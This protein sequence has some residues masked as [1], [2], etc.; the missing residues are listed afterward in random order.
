M[1]LVS[2][3]KIYFVDLVESGFLESQDTDVV[4]FQ[5]L[6]LQVLEGHHVQGV[7]NYDSAVGHRQKGVYWRDLIEEVEK[8]KIISYI[9]SKYCNLEISTFRNFSGSIRSEYP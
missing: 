7:R 6:L 1:N 4:S 3:C 8:F 9:I 2:F 5:K